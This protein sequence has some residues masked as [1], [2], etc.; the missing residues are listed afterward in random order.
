MSILIYSILYH[1]P[2]FLFILMWIVFFYF[3]FLSQSRDLSSRCRVWSE[4]SLID[5]CYLFHTIFFFW[6]MVPASEVCSRFYFC[7]HLSLVHFPMRVCC[8]LEFVIF[9]L[10]CGQCAP[11]ATMTISQLNGKWTDPFHVEKRTL[12]SVSLLIVSGKACQKCVESVRERT[13]DEEN[14]TECAGVPIR[15]GERR[16]LYLCSGERSGLRLRVGPMRLRISACIL[17]FWRHGGLFLSA[18]W[19]FRARMSDLSLLLASCSLFSFTSISLVLSCLSHFQL[20]R[21]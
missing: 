7:C 8:V 5:V 14:D 17:S 6:R 9:L 21:S 19:L 1:S 20:G 11:L 15:N 4:P 2:H 3:S 18:L 10:M 12:K 16:K 13:R